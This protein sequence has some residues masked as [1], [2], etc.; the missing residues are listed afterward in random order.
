VDEPG[1]SCERGYLKDSNGVDFAFDPVGAGSTEET[2]R[3]VCAAEGVCGL[4][5]GR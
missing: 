3:N 4:A 5:F 2:D 1:E